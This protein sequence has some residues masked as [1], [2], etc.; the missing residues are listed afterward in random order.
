MQILANIDEADVGKVHEGLAA[1]V[2]RRRVPRRDFNG[3]IRE[4][5]QAP[6]TIQNVV[7]YAAVIDAPNPDA[8]CARDDGLGD[9]R[10][11]RKDDALRVPNAALRW[12]PD[13]APRAQAAA[14][15]RGAAAAAARPQANGAAAE[16]A[17]ARSPGRRRPGLRAGER[18]S[19]VPVIDPRRASR[20]GSAPRS[21]TASPKA[22]R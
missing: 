20:T 14:K 1:E 13:E 7:T 12:K 10:P 19:A 9:D 3:I 8:S 21:W 18:Q 16:G 22:T 15:A 2:H 6:N 11:P 17:T 5:R 4:V